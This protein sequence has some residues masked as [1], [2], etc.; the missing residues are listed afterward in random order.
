MSAISS[1]LAGVRVLDLGQYLPGP[2][3]AQMLADLGADVLKIEPPGGDPLRA[4][5]PVGGKPMAGVSPYYAAINAGKKVA[6]L[7][8]KSADG[9]QAFERLAAAADVLIESFRP[10]RLA[11]IGLGP[12]RLRALNPRLVHVALSGYGRTGPLK[13]A[14]GHDLNYLAMTGALAASGS[15]AAPGMSW[16]PIADHAAAMQTALCVLGALLGRARTGQGAFV[17]VSLAET[18]LAWQ[19]W[20][21]TAAQAGETVARGCAVLNGGA[22]YY[23]VYGARDGKFVALGAIEPIFWRNFCAAVGHPEWIAR[24]N[25]PLPQAALIAEVAALFL[26][27]T[28]A[29]WDARLA[30]VDCCYHPVL[31]YAEVAASPQVA[32][33]GLV[34]PVAAASGI[35]A[36]METAFPAFVD[37]AA[38]PR[39]DPFQEIPVTAAL[40]AWNAAV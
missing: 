10:G 22:A 38:P 23:R 1:W 7:D 24:Q 19:A 29:E 8:L 3:A 2:A 40:A 16:P 5:D 33:R 20:G 32:A 36:H 21:L 13:D 14:S 9:R 28:R 18:A 31:D 11:R 34:R 35:P 30:T 12:D 39:R 4:L 17:D 27:G 25:E 37:G 6:R 26:A 15:E